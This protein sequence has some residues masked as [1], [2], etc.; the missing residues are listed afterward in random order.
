MKNLLKLIAIFSFVALIFSACKK[1]ENQVVFEGG[2]APVLSSTNSTPSF[3]LLKANENNNWSTFSW[4]NP[5]Y[6]F[7]TGV[8]SQD[9]TYTIQIDTMGAN[10]KNPNL[11]EITIARNLSTVITVKDINTAIAK[12]ELLENIPHTIEFRVK[13]TLQNGSVP[14]YSNV[15]KYILIPY[16]D[17]AVTLPSDLPI[18]GGNDGGLFLV[19]DATNGGWNNPVPVP[20]QKFT[21]TSSTTYEITTPL[22]GGKE[23]LMLPKNG[24]WGNKYAVA[25]KTLSGLSGGGEFGANKNDNFP[26]PSVSGTYKIVVNFKTGKFTVTK[27]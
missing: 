13:T 26:G 21:R 4:T 3:T 15:I 23:Y 9:V 2:T 14:L 19:G 11:Q 25:D 6:K 12:L 24:D 8:S 7:N 27:L 17:V 5:N 16:L 22:I 20:T 10:F 18:L 1:Q